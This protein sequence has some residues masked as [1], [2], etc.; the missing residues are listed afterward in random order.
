MQRIINPFSNDA[1]TA[2]SC[3]PVPI[4]VH[5]PGPAISAITSSAILTSCCWYPPSA[6]PTESSRKRFAWY[7]AS[8]ERSSNCTS[9]AHSAMFAVIVFLAGVTVL[10]AIVFPLRKV[11]VNRER[12]P[13]YAQ[14][15]QR[16]RSKRRTAIERRLEVPNPPRGLVLQ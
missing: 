5:D 3:S 1:D 12:D 6:Q 11:V 13:E 15:L 4:T 14:S 7:T 16:C 9:A 8:L 2:S 10:V